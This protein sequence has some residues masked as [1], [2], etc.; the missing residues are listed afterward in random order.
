MLIRLGHSADMGHM[1]FYKSAQSVFAG[2]H[3]WQS[4]HGGRRSF[5]LGLGSQSNSTKG[6]QSRSPGSHLQGLLDLVLCS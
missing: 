6:K 5:K 1:L 3:V 4:V 2:G